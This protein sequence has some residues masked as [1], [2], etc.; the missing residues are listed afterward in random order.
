MLI[1]RQ[2]RFLRSTHIAALVDRSVDR[3][4][5][6]YVGCSMPEMATGLARS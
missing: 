2:H 1:L 6:D 3:A 5:H 4:N